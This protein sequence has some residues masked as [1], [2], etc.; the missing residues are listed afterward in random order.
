M[1]VS[2][3]DKYRIY[4]IP[5]QYQLSHFH[6]FSSSL[7]DWMMSTLSLMWLQLVYFFSFLYF[8]R[9][10]KILNFRWFGFPY[11]SSLNWTVNRAERPLCIGNI[12]IGRTGVLLQYSLLGEFTGGIKQSKD[13]YPRLVKY[14][15]KQRGRKYELII[16]VTISYWHSVCTYLHSAF[17]VNG[18]HSRYK[19]KWI[20][21][22]WNRN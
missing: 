17:S 2:S 20:F 18:S 3:E 22:F 14:Y 21:I 16:E 10:A 5:F 7:T 9:S 13:F 15:W 19:S 12:C 11:F 4:G 6:F 1:L 8:G